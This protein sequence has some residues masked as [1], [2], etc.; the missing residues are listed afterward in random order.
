MKENHTFDS[1]F[2]HYPGIDQFGTNTA[3]VGKSI[4]PLGWLPDRVPT[5]INHDAKSAKIAMN[6]G[7]MNLFSHLTG[8]VKRGHDYADA[9]F[10]Q[11]VIPNYWTYAQDFGLADNFFSSV[12]GPSFPN[13]LVLIANQTDGAYDDPW[14]SVNRSWGCDS[15]PHARLQLR[16]ANGRDKTT[17]PCLNLFTLANQANRSNVSW[18]YYA[19]TAG[20]PGYIWD[21]YDAIKSIRNNPKYWSHADISYT[22]FPKDVANGNLAALTWLMPGYD[23]SDHPPESMC[24]GENWT[25]QQVNAVM[26]S[27]YWNSTAIILTWDDFGGFYDHIRPPKVDGTM[28]GPRVPAIVIS[29]YARPGFIDSSTY[30]FSSMVQFAEDVF[31]MPHLKGDSSVMPSLAPMFNF[32]QQPLQP[33]ILKERECQLSWS[34]RTI[35]YGTPLSSAQLA[36]TAGNVPGTFSY[37]PPLGTVLPAGNHTVT[38]T[39][40]PN[41][42]ADYATGSQLSATLTVNPAP[43]TITAGDA[44]MTYGQPVPAISPHY[45]GLRNGDT[46]PATPPACAASIASSVHPGTYET[47]CHGAADPNYIITT[48]NGVIKVTQATPNLQWSVPGAITY[49]SPLSASQLDPIA[50]VP[51]SFTYNV[52]SGQVLGQGTHTLTATFSPAD[53][54]DYV[55][56]TQISTTID[57][58]AAPLTITASSPTMTYGQAVP[59]IAPNYSGLENG[60]TGPAVAPT[61]STSATST[62]TVGAYGT[63]CSGA[64]D[65]NYAISYVDGSLTVSQ[66]T[67]QLSWT[68][69]SLTYGTPL[70]DAQLDATADTA[71]SFSYSPAAGAVLPA[72]QQTLTATFTPSDSTNYVSGGMVSAPLTVTPAQLSVTASSPLITYGDAI[73]AITPTYAGFQN[74][75]TAPMTQPTCS[76]T[77]TASS[78]AGTY[79]TTCSGAA[80]PNYTMAYTDGSLTIGQATPT[81]QWATPDQITTGTPLSDQQLDATSN[82]P[83][84]FTYDPSAGTSFSQSGDYTLTA[85]FT[86]DDTTDYVNGASVTTTIHV[87]PSGG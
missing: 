72:G 30:D 66:A 47:E 73:P 9:T 14:G 62:S 55:S 83:G 21:S 17:A 5:D 8:A 68:P 58:N 86:P 56:G 32:T 2:A 41:D 59:S 7:A 13:H 48:V 78:S 81:L 23:V 29:P 44:S 85:Y 71:G 42:T 63:T 82:V 84:S 77:A 74:G 75:D 50:D 4:V 27:Q 25:V 79:D 61:C 43:L 28:V 54:T 1:M 60:D 67:P 40:T 3:R 49:G 22:K 39:F 51:G 15:G 6:G 18:Q 64:S 16:A 20:Q 53:A 80:D 26:R 36:A 38:A 65:P 12:A 76:T 57:V 70:A 35:V 46:A 19:P 31:N 33:D 34:P 87:N 37:S 52:A 69:A 24:A 45:S 11:S 10:P